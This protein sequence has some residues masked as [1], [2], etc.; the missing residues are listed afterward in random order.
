MA[1][2]AGVLYR[3][4]DHSG[5]LCRADTDSFFVPSHIQMA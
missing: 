1:K 3:A 2:T 5:T 4:G